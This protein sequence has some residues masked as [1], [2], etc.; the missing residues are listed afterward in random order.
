VIDAYAHCGVSKYLPVE[1]VRSVMDGAGVERAVLCQHLGEY[2]N[3]YL[4]SVV[5]A[6]PERFTAV[7][8]V[9]ART[10]GWRGELRALAESGAFRGLRVVDDALAEQPAL[11]EEAAALGLVVVVYAPQGIARAVAPVRGLL[12]RQPD[13]TVEITHLGNPR[14]ETGATTGGFELLELAREPGV[15][16]TLSG[17]S[18]F[19]DY[20]HRELDDLIARTI[21]AFGTGRLLWGSNFPVGGDDQRAYDRDAGLIRPGRWG[22]DRSDVELV[23][24]GNARRIWFDRSQP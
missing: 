4:A 24:G 15:V 21:D 10:D 6:E 8:L 11:A 1:R 18:M 16:V 14:V 12:A 13:A 2:D 23:T 17:F 3:A 9:D 19:C 20:P 22:L 7:A 5:S